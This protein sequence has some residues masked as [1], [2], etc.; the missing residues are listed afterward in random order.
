[1]TVHRNQGAAA[2]AGVP[3]VVSR[4]RREGRQ[5][6]ADANGDTVTITVADGWS[7]FLDGRQR[8]GGE[9]LQVDPATA[10]HWIGRGWAV[11]APRATRRKRA[12]E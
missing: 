4:R 11:P 5:A 3:A 8:D 10:E 7:V 12:D 6:S 2:G 9:Q 1:M